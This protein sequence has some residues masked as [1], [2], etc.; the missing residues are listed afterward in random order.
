MNLTEDESQTVSTWLKSG[1]KVMYVMDEQGLHRSLI[2]R[3]VEEGCAERKEPPQAGLLAF[4]LTKLGLL[5]L[6]Q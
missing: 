2:Q 3:L 1:G 4:R 6:V 5:S